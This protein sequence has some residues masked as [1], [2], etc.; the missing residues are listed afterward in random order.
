MNNP[1]AYILGFSLLSRG[2][3]IFLL[4]L[5]LED[6]KKKNGARGALVSV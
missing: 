2:F 5:G 4:F 3:V 1:I 6:F